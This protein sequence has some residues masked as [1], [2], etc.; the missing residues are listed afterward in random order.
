M[1]LTRTLLILFLGAISIPA[2]AG[3][4]Q[5]IV[6]TVNATEG[7]A[8]AAMGQARFNPSGGSLSCNFSGDGI[9][10]Q[11]A[12][13]DSAGTRVQC[14]ASAVASPGFARNVRAINGASF[15][16]LFWNPATGICYDMR[17]IQGSQ[18]LSDYHGPKPALSANVY[19]AQ[20]DWAQ[21]ALSGVRYNNDN[22]NDFISCDIWASGYIY[23][24]ARSGDAVVACHTSEADDPVA[25]A[26]VRT[27]D[28][29]SHVSFSSHTSAGV[30]KN[31]SVDKGT[32]YLP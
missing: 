3:T 12:A 25:A 5:T 28:E 4:K 6:T 21:G 7:W 9:N 1:H 20:P 24:M 30:C 22:P 2:T 19:I 31:I 11:C 16:A 14:A 8:Y 15:V 17:L 13:S 27:I 32:S 18:F 29:V 10:I 26:Q 23:C